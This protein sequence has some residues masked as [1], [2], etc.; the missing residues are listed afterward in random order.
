MGTAADYAYWT[1]DQFRKTKTCKEGKSYGFI[2]T[3][4]FSFFLCLHGKHEPL[5]VFVYANIKFIHFHLAVATH[6]RTN[7][8]LKMK[9]G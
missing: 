5:A 4:S 2:Q 7:M 6:M 8:R 9:A 1:T 3:Q